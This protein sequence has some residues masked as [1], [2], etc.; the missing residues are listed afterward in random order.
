MSKKH[1]YP[2][3]R[4]ARTVEYSSSYKLLQIV[5]EKKFRELFRVHGMYNVARILSQEL[6]IEVSPYV[7]RHIRKKYELGGEDNEKSNN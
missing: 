3:T 2:K 7:I 1:N 5:G 4:K 6:S